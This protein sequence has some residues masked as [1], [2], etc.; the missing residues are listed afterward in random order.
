L[1]SKTTETQGR[2][3]RVLFDTGPEAKSIARNLAALQTPVEAIERIVLSHWHRDHSGGIIA[4][5]EQVTLARAKKQ[6][7][8]GQSGE[9]APVVVDLHPDRPIARGI[10]PPPSG[11]VICRLPEDPTHS[12]IL[13]A[14]GVVETHAEGHLVAGDS[15]W[16]SGEIP[17]VTSFEAGLLGGARWRE[18]HS[19]ASEEVRG[20]WVPEVVSP[21]CNTSR[22]EIRGIDGHPPWSAGHHG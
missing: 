4:A 8:P 13:A 7:E 1:F 21:C 17:R 3:H 9:P 5:L 12:D 6:V 2:I 15:V 16:V 11:K 22:A 20:E 19:A 18:F 14:G 10:A